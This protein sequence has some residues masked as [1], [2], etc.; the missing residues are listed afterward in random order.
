MNWDWDKLQE[1]RQQQQKNGWGSA[2][3]G[4]LGKRRR[5]SRRFPEK[6]QPEQAGRRFSQGRTSF[7][8]MAQGSAD[9][10]SAENALVDS[11]RA[12]GLGCFP[13]STSFSP[14]NPAWC[15]ASASTC[16]PKIPDRHIHL[17]L[18]HRNRV[19]GQGFAGAS[20]G[21]GLSR[22]VRGRRVPAGTRA[23]G[24]RGIGHAHGR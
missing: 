6:R 1:K 15:F 19:Q 3:Q 24:Q 22:P 9:R 10:R 5:R 23:G 20:D 14:T 13:A 4:Q 12:G 17:P 21:R 18:P 16:A 7:V 8:F 2:G 11:W